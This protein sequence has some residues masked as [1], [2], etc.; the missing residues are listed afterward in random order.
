MYFP[1]LLPYFLFVHWVIE[2]V[3][4]LDQAYSRLGSSLDHAWTGAW[5]NTWTTLHL[6]LAN[7]LKHRECEGFAWTTRRLDRLPGPP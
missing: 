4:R 1:T 7:A 5:T 6:P 2:K 3:D